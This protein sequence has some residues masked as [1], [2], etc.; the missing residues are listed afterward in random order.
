MSGHASLPPGGAGEAAARRAEAEQLL[1]PRPGTVGDLLRSAAAR[2]PQRDALVFAD[3]SGDTGRR[4]TYARLEADAERVAHRLLE[5]LEPGERVAVWAANSPEWILAQLGLALA[6]LVLV[7]VNPAATEEETAHL[8]ADSGAAVLL[9]DRRYRELDRAAALGRLS[10]G[11]PQLRIVVDLDDWTDWL[12]GD[13]STSALPVVSPADPAQL[14][15]TSGTT[16]RPKGAVLHHGGLTTTPVVA[17]RLFDLGEAPRW[18]NAMPLCHI[19]GCGLPVL[20]SLAVGGT[21]VLAERYRADLVLEL[22]ARER[23]TFFGGVPAMIVDLL[24]RHDPQR[25][26]I[27]SL[28]SLLTGAAEVSPAL[29]TEVERVLGVSFGVAYGQTESHGHIA[30]TRPDDTPVDKAGTIGQPLPHVEVQIVDAEGHELEAGQPGELWCRSVAVMDGYRNNPE[31]TAQAL[32]GGGWLRT[33]DV[34][35][36]DARGFL[37]FHGRIGELINRGGEKFAPREIE[38]ALIAH[39]TVATAAVF[40]VPDPRLGSRVAAAVVPAGSGGWDPAELSAF[41]ATRLARFKIPEQWLAV[42]EL[43]VTASGKVARHR[44]REL[45]DQQG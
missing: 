9:A 14:L 36:R 19:G 22:I 30:Q 34:C 39:P 28:R 25:H 29:V 6:G 15:Y 8:L 5:D 1:V 38:D 44:L 27:S 2:F 26:D 4:W 20:G 13:R 10:A 3:A 24:E 11:L 45:W 41:L 43:P 23:I 7:P 12:E 16:G 42:D 37:T 21:H 17:T 18:L 33:G 32:P 31:A 40:G 35:S